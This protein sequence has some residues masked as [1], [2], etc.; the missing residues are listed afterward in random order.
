MQFNVECQCDQECESFQDCCL[1]YHNFC[2]GVSTDTVPFNASSIPYN[3]FSCSEVSVYL[4]TS[5]RIIDQCPDEF[6][7]E[8]IREKCDRK[9][10]S[11][12]YEHTASRYWPVYNLKGYN[13]RNMFCAICNRQL[14]MPLIFWHM[15]KPEEKREEVSSTFDLHRNRRDSDKN[16][17]DTFRSSHCK[18]L[19]ETSSSRDYHKKSLVYTG[20]RIRPC[21]TD[22]VRTCPSTYMNKSVLDACEIFMSPVCHPNDK[23]LVAQYTRYKNPYCLLCNNEDQN[24]FTTCEVSKQSVFTVPDGYLSAIWHF[25]NNVYVKTKR[26][27]SCPPEEMYDVYSGICR[28]VMCAPG[29][30]RQN[31][32]CVVNPSLE[33]II[34]SQFCVQERNTIIAGGHPNNDNI[35]NCVLDSLGVAASETNKLHGGQSLYYSATGKLSSADVSN[36]GAQFIISQLKEGVAN[37]EITKQLFTSCKARSFELIHSCQK[38]IHGSECSGKWFSGSPSDFRRVDNVTDEAEVY[39]YENTY[40]SPE[41]ALCV[42]T[43]KL[44]TFFD[45]FVRFEECFVCGFA[46]PVLDCPLLTIYEYEYEI[47]QRENETELWYAN[48]KLQQDNYLILAD[49]RGMICAPDTQMIFA[50]TDRL[51]IVNFVGT[52]LSLAGLAGTFATY[53]SL[54]NLRNSHGIHMMYL[55][56]SLFM[57]QLLPLI[58]ANFQIYSVPCTALAVITHFAWLASFSW[59]TLIAANMTY[60]FA[61]KPFNSQSGT[62]VPK[63]TSARSFHVLG[64]GI[65]FLI[66]A[67]CVVLQVAKP[68]GINFQYDDPQGVCWI[69]EVHANLIAFGIPVAMSVS[70]NSILFIWTMYSLRKNKCELESL[71]QRTLATRAHDCLNDTLLFMK[72]G[73]RAISFFF[74]YFCLSVI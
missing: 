51:G 60:A 22:L 14:V 73:E 39:L 2:K 34:E 9:I 59:M 35:T 26:R 17:T 69:S 68:A 7:H 3:L 71:N 47:V 38:K 64:W 42:L 66:V 4:P 25:Q 32:H 19:I 43:F 8:I 61:Y 48:H 46:L 11:L 24:V 13:F 63:L 67:T 6:E 33:S 54:A 15:G 55:T 31:G 58:T 62:S 50:Y 16:E 74:K 28:P 41:F 40:I 23:S 45:M 57:A 56:T 30:Q 53:V 1:D 10:L 29:F 37:E 18:F 36:H 5:Y 27:D 49:G 52:V 72:V 20:Y 12:N 21:I 65:P 44:D 70:V